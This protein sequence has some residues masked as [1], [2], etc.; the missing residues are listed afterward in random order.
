MP[1]KASFVDRVLLPSVTSTYSRLF[2]LCSLPTEFHWSTEDMDF[3]AL[4][5]KLISIEWKNTTV[6]YSALIV[7]MQEYRVPLKTVTS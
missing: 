6:R 5:L 1:R 7:K 2:E 4:L 3:K